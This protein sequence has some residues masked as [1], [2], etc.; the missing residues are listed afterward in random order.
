[1]YFNSQFTD[2]F[3]GLAAHNDRD[4]FQANKKIYENEVKK[5]FYQLVNDLLSATNSKIQVKDAVFRINRDIRFSKDKSPYQLHVSA[6]ISD[7]GRKDMQ[8]PGLYIQLSAHQQWIGGGMYM[9]DKDNLLKIRKAIIADP[10]KFQK[11]I[12]DK[13]FASVYGTIKGDKNKILPKELKGLADDNP[14][15]YNKQFYFMAEYEDENLPC[16]EDLLPFI[17][18]HYKASEKLNRYFADI[19]ST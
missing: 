8:Y 19:I 17:L 12:D 14:W 3:K 1:M 5:P 18:Q 6:I 10:K 4:W 13:N 11:L 15:V 16:R 9:P 7:G 2:F